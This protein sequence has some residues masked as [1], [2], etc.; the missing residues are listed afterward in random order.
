MHQAHH[1]PLLIYA[2]LYHTYYQFP[3][4]Q[5]STFKK[6]D[7]ETQAHHFHINHSLTLSSR[8]TS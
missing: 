8:F 7:C 1:T 2:H 5:P 3:V 6:Q 4:F